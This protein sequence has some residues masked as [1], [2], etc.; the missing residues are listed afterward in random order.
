MDNFFK[1]LFKK[2]HFCT[3]HG[4]IYRCEDSELDWEWWQ[5]TLK[6]CGVDDEMQAAVSNPHYF[7]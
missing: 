7:E 4:I 1:K 6:E 3:E 2:K 5:A